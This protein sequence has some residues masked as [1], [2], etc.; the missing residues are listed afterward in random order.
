VGDYTRRLAAEITEQGHRCHLLAL[1]D[2]RVKKITAGEFGDANGLIPYLRLPAADSWPERVHQAKNFCKGIAPDWISWQIV[3]YGFDRRGLS[4]GMGG[5]FKEISGGCKNEVMFH[6]IWIGEAE[7]SSLKNRI[8]GKLQRLIIKDFLQKLQPRVVHTHTPLYQHLLGRLGCR[9]MI[10][11]L[12]GNIP[13]MMNP[14][15]EWLKEKWPEHWG[16]FNAAARDSWWIFVVFGSIHPEWDADDFLRRASAAAQRAGKKCLF[17][18]IGRPGADGERTLQELQKHEGN[19]WR[20]LNL[21]RQTEEDISQCLLMADFGVSTVPP[22]YVFKSGTAAAMIEHGLQVI[23]TRPS[24]H[25]SNCPPEKLSI[26]MRNVV[27]DFNLE[28]LKKSK[29]GSLLPA[30]AGQFIE[31]LSQ[32][33]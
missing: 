14:R 3:P 33:P 27:T 25:Y 6:E 19:S 26:G 11:P 31:D 29:A 16:Q 28:A 9:A 32:A 7:G 4:F 2:S 12:F 20:F 10:L 21:G 1:A 23:A 13:I 5:R 24:Y 30:V 22:E 15:S 8:T 17:I 18:S